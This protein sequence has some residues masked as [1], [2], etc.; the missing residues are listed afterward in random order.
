MGGS[1]Y[2]QVWQGLCDCSS[3]IY[4]IIYY[5]QKNLKLANVYF[6]YNFNNKNVIIFNIDNKMVIMKNKLK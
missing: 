4:L 5:I 6:D 2:T 3:Y 1:I